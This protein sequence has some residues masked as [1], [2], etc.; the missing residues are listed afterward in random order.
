V[1]RRGFL[2]AVA[3]IPVAVVAA[4]G[5]FI[6]LPAPLKISRTL[7]KRLDMNIWQVYYCATIGA[8]VEYQYAE[9]IDIPRKDPVPASRLA[10]SDTAAWHAFDRAQKHEA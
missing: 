10:V 4:K 6:A 2:K 9:L 1:N 7:S 3:A 8:G 5:A